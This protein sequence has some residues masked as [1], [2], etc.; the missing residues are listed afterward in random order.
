MF[1]GSSDQTPK[2]GRILGITSDSNCGFIK[3]GIVLNKLEKSSGTLFYPDV[4]ELQTYFS[5]IY[6]PLAESVKIMDRV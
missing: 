1:F 5:M 3:K 6:F 4:L 2:K